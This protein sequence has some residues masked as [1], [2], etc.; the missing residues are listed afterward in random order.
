MTNKTNI[1]I[2]NLKEVAYW[3]SI[4]VF[5]FDLTHSKS[6]GQANLDVD[7]LS[8]GTDMINVEKVPYFLQLVYFFDFD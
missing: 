4:R 3:L 1:V 7:Y 2:A 8:K 5:T 6:Q